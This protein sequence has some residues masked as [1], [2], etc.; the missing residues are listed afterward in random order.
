M[1]FRSELLLLLGPVAVQIVRRMKAPR[2]PEVQHE[3][4]RS[5]RR[6]TGH[7]CKA[8]DS[9][10]S[11]LDERRHRRYRDGQMHLLRRPLAI[12]FVAASAVFWGTTRAHA[13]PGYPKVVQDAT[14]TD[15]ATY[16]P[17]HGCQLCHVTA[18][19]GT[20]LNSFGTR[21]VQ[22]YGLSTSTT[23]VD[24]SLMAALQGLKMGDPALFAD[25]QHGVDPNSLHQG[26]ETSVLSPRYGCGASI[27]ATSGSLPYG[28]FV[29]FVLVGAW[30]RRIRATA[31]PVRRRFRAFRE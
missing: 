8:D 29:A 1:W 17:P 3:T 7:Q 6:Q 21:L 13:H 26:A 20:P 15:P 16:D 19:G 5:R 22:T 24:D 2:L 11:V 14:G 31:H 12:A 25:L 23:E 28:A 4:G 27:G 9:Q 10:Q 30:R 18:E